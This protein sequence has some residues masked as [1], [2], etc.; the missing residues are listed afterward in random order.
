[1]GEVRAFSPADMEDYYQGVTWRVAL[2]ALGLFE[3]PTRRSFPD[4][5]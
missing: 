2:G 4:C 3:R 5:K 1:M